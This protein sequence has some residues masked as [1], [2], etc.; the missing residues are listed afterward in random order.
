MSRVVLGDVVILLSPLCFRLGL[1]SSVEQAEIV[2]LLST[3]CLPVYVSTRPSTLDIKNHR[4][5]VFLAGFAWVPV[6]WAELVSTVNCYGF[7][8]L[9]P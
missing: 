1:L 2:S 9:Q 8:L 5:V 7:D 4:F 6:Y 3:I